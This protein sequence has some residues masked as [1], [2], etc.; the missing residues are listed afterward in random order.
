MTRARQLIVLGLLVEGAL[1][2]SLG[3]VTVRALVAAEGE[4]R[5][6]YQQVADRLF[7]ELERELDAVVEREEGRSFLEYRYVYVPDDA[8]A[9]QEGLSRSPLSKWPE[10]PW[11]RGY[12]QVDPDGRVLLP[13]EPR[14]GEVAV[15]DG[16]VSARA[17]AL[18]ARLQPV[19][20]GGLGW[21]GAPAEA[22]APPAF[23]ETTSGNNELL[24]LLNRGSSR[25]APQTRQRATKVSTTQAANYDVTGSVAKQGL[26]VLTPA[27][28]EQVD[29]NITGL[30]GQRV[31]ED[32]VLHRT[33]QIGDT[34][35][36]QGLLV[37]PDLLEAELERAVLAHSRDPASLT[38]SRDDDQEPPPTPVTEVANALRDHIALRWDAASPVAGRFVFEHRFAP[39]FSTLRAHATISS[40]PGTS[41][42]GRSTILF[43]SGFSALVTLLGGAVA[44]WAVFAELRL[45]QRRSD[46]VSAVTHELKT[47]LTSIRL[48]GEMLQSG[49]ATD[50][51][52]RQ[53]YYRTI[54]AEAERLSRLIQNVLD[55]GRIE[56]HRRR[57]EVGS[58]DVSGLLHRVVE[59][60]GPHARDQGFELELD[61]HEPLPSAR[62]DA[63]AM[64]QV[65]VNL[66]DNAVKFSAGATDRRISLR[67]F[68]DQG[69]VIE[70]RDRGPGVTAAVQKRMFEPFFRGEAEL[71]RRTKGTGIG[72]ALAAALVGESGGRVDARN[73]PEG[74]L[75][76]RIRLRRVG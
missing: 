22:L 28:A 74:G 27:D 61:L 14:D 16:Q 57:A 35:Y 40:L 64:T 50:E 66:V 12:F 3:L 8:V 24:S 23:A 29:V 71:V 53:D 75:V 47:P 41:S 68:E 76:V 4:E 18:R 55:F 48:Y 34:T 65:L 10:E 5:A 15:V 2:G 70:V 6:A 13:T 25:S 72:L 58:G 52:T 60:I 45:A 1:L 63:D 32:L 17:T 43:L 7:D 36:R 46:F 67:A 39:P 30:F 21:G 49:M 31:G 59:V 11:I 73:H 38:R 51:A 56:R 9:G 69:V 62:F 44:A 33:V 26:H 42:W 20:D 37:R 54:T 19:L